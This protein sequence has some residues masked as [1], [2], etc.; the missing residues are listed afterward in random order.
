MNK[1]QKTLFLPFYEFDTSKSLNILIVC[2]DEKQT[3]KTASLKFWTNPDSPCSD[4]Y[5]KEILMRHEKKHMQFD[6]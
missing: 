2:L 3:N 1:N 6:H 4:N 5:D